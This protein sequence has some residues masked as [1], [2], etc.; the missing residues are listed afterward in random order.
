M[1]WANMA[2]KT[3]PQLGML[4]AIPN[5]GHRSAIA[6]AKMKAEGV[7]RGV[8]DLCLPVASKGFHGLYIELKTPQ[9]GRLSQEQKA[10]LATLAG[11][12][13]QA[14]VCHGWEQARDA[15]VGYLEA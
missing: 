8:P 2:A 6:G 15:I 3:L 13:Y 1:G 12:G 4:F 7:R 14:I 5:G 11:N 10:W 9:K